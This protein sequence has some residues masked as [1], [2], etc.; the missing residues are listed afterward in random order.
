MENE[1]II[2]GTEP[3]SEAPANQNGKTC[4]LCGTNC[5]DYYVF[6]S[7]CGAP[8]GN[9][10]PVNPAEPVAIPAEPV[11]IP[12][13]PVA[14]PSEP[15]AAPAEPYAAPAEPFAAPAEP[16]APPTF[17]PPVAQPGMPYTYPVQ[18]VEQPKKKKF[19]K[20]KLFWVLVVL[21]GIVAVVGISSSGGS[22]GGSSS[23]STY[24]PS[25]SPYVRMVKEATHSS[26]G[27]TYGKAF[28]S[29]FSSPSW[30]SFTA[31]SGETVV[32]FEGRFSYQNSPA[33]A[34]IQFV[35]DLSGGTFSAYHLSINGVAQNKLMLATLIKKVFESAL[36]YY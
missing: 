5:P 9:P 19:Y 3:Q 15:F 17:T 25:V 2:P 22:S 26:Y 30:S 7:S 31:T 33:T 34:K 6:C 32:E 28:N 36:G 14:I 11:A 27:I 8:L 18:P 20:R 1:N 35:L 29:F 10:A 12:A 16:Y 13:E 4:T 23:G 21:I 24:V